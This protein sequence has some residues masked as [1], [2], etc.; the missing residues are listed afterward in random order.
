MI[1]ILLKYMPVCCS[2][3]LDADCEDMVFDTIA[4]WGKKHTETTCY[5]NSELLLHK[6]MWDVL[7]RDKQG[8]RKEHS[9]VDWCRRIARI[10]AEGAATEHA[11]NDN[12]FQKLAEDILAHDLTAE[13][14]E[15]PI[16]W[17]CEGKSI[18][19]KHAAPSTSSCDK[20]WEM[21]GSL[22]TYSSTA[23]LHCW[24]H[25]GRGGRS[26]E[27]IYRTYWKSL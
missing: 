20:T 8:L 5:L 25:I 15:N 22:L 11:N 24:I 12:R 27:H 4:D 17:I 9:F 10:D 19:T 3:R 6:K 23:F 13:Q 1:V 26:K 14:K 2:P 7:N 18:T 16:Y 21:P